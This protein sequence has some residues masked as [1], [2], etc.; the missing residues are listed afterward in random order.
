MSLTIAEVLYKMNLENYTSTELED[1]IHSAATRHGSKPNL[2]ACLM[3][4]LPTLCM[5]VQACKKSNAATALVREAPRPS[6]YRIWTEGKEIVLNSITSYEKDKNR[7]LLWIDLDA[8][9]QVSPE[10]PKHT[11]DPRAVQLLRYLINHI[12][13]LKSIESVIKDIYKN[14]PG[15]EEG[16]DKNKIAQHITQLNNFGRGR[17]KFSNFLFADWRQNGLGLT[18]D[19]KN[20]YFLFKRVAP[21]TD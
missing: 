10:N 5:E 6:S 16:Y 1:L 17:I 21:D 19:F 13:T 9:K 12:G 3:K 18:E 2:T 11:L 4:N 20:N 7:Y 8:P 14:D 15:S